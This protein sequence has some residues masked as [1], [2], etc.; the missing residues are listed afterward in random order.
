[1]HKSLS[2]LVVLNEV[3][4]SGSSGWFPFYCLAFNNKGSI[5]GGARACGRSAGIYSGRE[6]IYCN[7]PGN[8][9]SGL[10]CRVHVNILIW[11]L[12]I[13]FPWCG[14]FLQVVSLVVTQF[15]SHL[16]K[17]LVLTNRFIDTCLLFSGKDRMESTNHSLIRNTIFESNMFFFDCFRTLYS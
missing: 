8:L 2:Y 10:W 17:A 1:M 12:N 15:R 9:V 14:L 3:M 7:E 11:N 16:S 4:P 6:C 5:W 13:Q